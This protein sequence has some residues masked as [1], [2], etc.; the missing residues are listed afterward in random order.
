MTQPSRFS[1][2]IGALLV[3]GLALF[4]R[5]RDLGV[6]S[7]DF[8]EYLHVFAGQQL[9]QRG[10]PLL[11]SG[12]P[13]TRAL[14]YTRMVSQSIRWFGA[15]E[16]AVRLPSVVFGVGLVLLA[17]WIAWRWAGGAGAALLVMV[18]VAI[19][20][21]CLQMSRVCR[22]YAP[23]HLLYL[24][25]LY[26]AYEAFEGGGSWKRRVGWGVAALLALAISVKLQ[27]LAVDL[28]AGMAGYAAVQAALTRQRKYGGLILLGVAAGLAAAALGM[29][30]LVGL[31]REANWAPAYAASHRYDA[32]FYLRNGWSVDPWMVALI[33]P[34]LVWWVIRDAR[35]GWF[36]ACAIVIPAAL[37]SL[38]FD[39]KQERYLLHIM[40]PM[41]L[42]IGAALWWAAER[43]SKRRPALVG[44]LLLA[45]IAMLSAHTPRLTGLDGEVA[46][47]RGAFAAL[48]SQITPEDQL[49]VTVPLVS[50]YYFHQRLPDYIT[51]NPLIDDSGY[52]SA[53]AA[54]G[55]YRDWY[56][57]RPLI[58]DA[59][60]M[61]RVFA[62]HPTGWI[63][64]DRRRFPYD[65]CVPQEVRA[66][67]EQRCR[68]WPSPDPSVIVYTWG[69]G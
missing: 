68:R 3:G 52:V 11:P 4:L 50:A 69:K 63:V 32:G 65:T 2:V 1:W 14:P 66:L 10:R 37:H 18:L 51:L 62:S 60:E 8:D 24:G 39:W 57:G 53:R 17:G 40:A 16:A 19:D 34:A 45:P 41:L 29:V 43:L 21:Y 12:E 59:K 7:L 22:M 20:P 49:I 30:D 36:L 54:D 42:A 35:R 31:W 38:I 9:L 46:N 58:T 23:F 48:Q 67:I 27:K 15:S 56:T 5:V 33:V 44:A 26:A 6:T 55:L 64:A 13:Y 47:W 25:A 61:A 28:V